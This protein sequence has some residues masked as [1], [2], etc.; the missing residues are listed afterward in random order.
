MDRSQLA[1]SQVMQKN[2]DPYDVDFQALKNSYMRDEMTRIP[3]VRA[4]FKHYCKNPF[5]YEKG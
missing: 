5:T 4:I 3:F 2:A 1:A